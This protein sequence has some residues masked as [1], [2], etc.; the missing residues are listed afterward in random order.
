MTGIMSLLLNKRRGTLVLATLPVLMLGTVL[1]ASAAPVTGRT[2]AHSVSAFSSTVLTAAGK[3]VHSDLPF[4]AYD[5]CAQYNYCDYN[6]TDGALKC[7]QTDQAINDW[8]SCANLDE[9]FANRM[10]VH[11]VRVYFSAGYGGAWACVNPGWYANNLDIS[12]YIFNN[13]SGL[14]GYGQRILRNVHSSKPVLSSQ[15]NGLCTNP[16]PEDG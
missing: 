13:G 16:L 2:A 14:P 12:A 11:G 4:Q 1:T 6:G 3:T 7:I 15:N 10:T 9:S 8:G 5:H